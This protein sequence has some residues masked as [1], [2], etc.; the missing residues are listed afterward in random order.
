MYKLFKIRFNTNG[1]SLFLKGSIATW[2]FLGFLVIGSPFFVPDDSELSDFIATLF[3]ALVPFILG[4]IVYLIVVMLEEDEEIMDKLCPSFWK[5]EFR[6]AVMHGDWTKIY[7]YA[8]EFSKIFEKY[9]YFYI[10]TDTFHDLPLQQLKRALNVFAE[11]NPE[12][13]TAQLIE[14]VLSDAEN[15][16][17]NT[18]LVDFSSEE[19]LEIERVEE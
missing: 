3:V 4:A 10:C 6:R 19:K 8:S 15:G 18:Y 12:Y 14:T 17:E 7:A 1:P 11:K 16:L 5:K 9:A 13:F 2:L